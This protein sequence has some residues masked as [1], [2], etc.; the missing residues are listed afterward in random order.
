M[1][2]NTQRQ[3]SPKTFLPRVK[4]IIIDKERSTLRV[5]SLKNHFYP[6][7]DLYFHKIV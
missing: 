6:R 1:N 3:L 2:F 7:I 4:N 5:E